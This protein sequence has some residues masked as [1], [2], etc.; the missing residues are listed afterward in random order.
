MQISLEVNS[1]S[2]VNNFYRTSP[3][4]GGL[5][6]AAVAII[7]PALLWAYCDSFWSRYWQGVSHFEKIA[8][9]IAIFSL[10]TVFYGYSFNY[11][12]S[13]SFSVY[14]WAREITW[15]E[16]LTL[17]D[18]FFFLI[19]V[20]L[21]W[22]QLGYSFNGRSPWKIDLN[23]TLIG[24]A[25]A[26]TGLGIFWQISINSLGAIATVTF[27]LFLFL[28]AIFVIR[29]SLTTGKRL[30]FWW[31]IAVVAI[32]ILSRMLEYNTGLIFKALVLF[33]CGVAIIGAGIWFER[34]LQR[35]LENN[36]TDVL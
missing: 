33:A 16:W 22:W 8:H 3:V 36:S 19:L 13:H 14:N 17:I 24:G 11:F 25:I 34:Y 7:P 5:V 15:Q 23:S 4:I 27:N 26:I 1:S 9:N 12:W 18:L 10:S 28:L 20:V 29:N 30:G 32:Q 31:G 35:Q 21:A 6:F 2:L